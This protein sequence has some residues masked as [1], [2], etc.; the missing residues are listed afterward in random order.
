MTVFNMFTNHIDRAINKIGAEGKAIDLDIKFNQDLKI[1]KMR[2]NQKRVFENYP[3][4]QYFSMIEPMG[5]GKSMTLKYLGT[6]L[7]EDNED[8]KI[9]IV[10][11]RT[12]IANTFKKET[13]EYPNGTIRKWDI[14][15]N[16]CDEHYDKLDIL[17]SFLKKT[18]FPKGIH[19]RVCVTTHLAFSM[20]QDKVGHIGD[21]FNNTLIIIDEAHHILC[22]EYDQ[23]QISNQIG[24]IVYKILKR[25]HKSTSLWLV[26]ATLFRGDRGDIIPPNMYDM[27]TEHFLPFDQHW[28]ENIEYIETFEYNFVIYKDIMKDIQEIVGRNKEKTIIFCPYNGHLLKGRD[29]FQFGN[30][31]HQKIKEVWPDYQR[32]DLIDPDGRE[33]RKKELET[34]KNASKID[35]IYALKLFDEGTDWKYASQGIDAAPR[36]SLVIQTQKLGRI[37]RDLKGKKHVSYYIFFPN[38]DVFETE[39][40]MVIHL[41]KMFAIMAGAMILREAIQPLPYPQLPEPKEVS[42]FEEAVPNPKNRQDIIQKISEELVSYASENPNPTPTET[43][44]KIKEVLKEEFNIDDDEDYSITTHIGLMLNQLGK[45]QSPII[46]NIPQPDWKLS[47][48]IDWMVEAGFDKIFDKSI[49]DTL[50]MFGTAAAGV[51]TFDEFREIFNSKKKQPTYWVRI[52]NELSEKNDGI[53][54]LLPPLRLLPLLKLVC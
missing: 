21:S 45:S 9:I 4:E 10:V 41:K 11:P 35:I 50:L 39:Q 25:N 26:S 42:P 19:S 8:L 52:A 47:M 3:S 24:G 29:K 20:L 31:L 1:I 14:G 33:K 22:S 44:E 13:L 23:V 15:K 16:L 36:N 28:K 5:A 38:Q 30:E 6:K 34:E 18:K 37:L 46:N 40:D 12:L 43:R 2:P 49:Y 27:F 32:L 53:L 48:N 17:V 7:L 51:E 54:Y